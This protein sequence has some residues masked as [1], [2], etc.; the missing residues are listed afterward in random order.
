MHKRM[1]V[2]PSFSLNGCYR[3]VDCNIRGDEY[4][5]E[6]GYAPAVSLLGLE[7]V[8]VAALK[9]SRMLPL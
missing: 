2:S 5:Q 3:G 1:V 7:V 8:L 9:E 6:L 4:M